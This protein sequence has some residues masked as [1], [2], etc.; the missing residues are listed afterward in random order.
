MTKDYGHNA[1]HWPHPKPKDEMPKEVYAN[2]DGW[3]SAEDTDFKQGFD[4]KYHHDSEV[5]DLKYDLRS[6]MKA[7]SELADE[8]VKRDEIIRDLVKGFETLIEKCCDAEG[9]PMFDLSEEDAVLT[10]HAE[11]IKEIVDET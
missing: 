5:Q 6:Y 10:K 2:K 1:E 9:D 3:V 7:S 11:T 4:E 8:L